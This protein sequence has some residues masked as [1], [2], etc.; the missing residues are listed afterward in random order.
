[1]ILQMYRAVEVKHKKG[2]FWA[3]QYHPEYDLHE[4]A[5]LIIAREEKLI[6]QNYFASKEDLLNYAEDLEK[7]YSDKNRK[8]LRWKYGIDDDV[9][10]DKIRQVEFVNWLNKIVIPYSNK[11]E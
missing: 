1:M 2:I 5:R 7:I 4:I 6:K 10:D 3:P 8:D 9:I 11:T